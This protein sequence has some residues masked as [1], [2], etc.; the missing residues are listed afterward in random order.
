MKDG[1][2]LLDWESSFDEQ[3]SLTVGQKVNLSYWIYQHNL[4]SRLLDELSSQ[5]LQV[6]GRFKNWMND[7]RDRVLKLDKDWVEGHRD[8][9]P[10]AED[11]ML[12]FLR[13]SIRDWDADPE[14]RQPTSDLKM[15]A[16]DCRNSNDRKELEKHAAEQGWLGVRTER[17]FRSMKRVN[18]SARVYV[19][20]QPREADKRF[21]EQ[22]VRE[23][24]FVAMWFDDSMLEA[25]ERGIEPAIC[26]AGY[27]PLRID[28]EH[29]VGPVA[30]KIVAEIGKSRFVVADLTGRAES[31]APGGVYYEAT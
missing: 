18:H 8:R 22:D 9:E 25:Y 30:D 23:Q 7:H 11:R 17:G 4:D 3:K 16:G 20:D 29:Y 6:R 26:A 15:A 19:D 1:A 5:D 21:H 28:R 2:A 10:S 31:G 27:K 13:E 12:N 24:V 14:E